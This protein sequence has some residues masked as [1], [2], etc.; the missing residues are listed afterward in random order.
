MVQQNQDDLIHH[1]S[2]HKKTTHPLDSYLTCD[3]L[4]CSFNPSFFIF[5]F[6]HSFSLSITFFLHSFISLSFFFLSS[7][8]SFPTTAGTSWRLTTP[9]HGSASTRPPTTAGAVCPSTCSSSCNSTTASTPSSDLHHH[10]H[11]HHRLTAATSVLFLQYASSRHE[12][13]SSNCN[14]RPHEATPS[15]YVITPLLIRHHPPPH[16]SSPTLLIRHH[17]PFSYVITPLLIRHH[18]P[19]SYVITPSQLSLF[20]LIHH[21]PS[22]H[23]SAHASH[24]GSS[25]LLHHPINSNTHISELYLLTRHSIL[26]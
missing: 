9:C 13:S 22:T 12:L 21:L 1:S 8:S 2:N 24:T 18:P 25:L 10:L 4:R 23:H 20:L 14:M 17:P 11:H 7:F 6:L 16:T 3:V 19:S 15:S 26:S 5:F